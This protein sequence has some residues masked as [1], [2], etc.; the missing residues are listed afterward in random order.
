MG[1]VIDRT[2]HT[3]KFTHGRDDNRTWCG[4]PCASMYLA[5]MEASAAVSTVVHSK[6]R[7]LN[8]NTVV[9]LPE[10]EKLMLINYGGSA[11]AELLTHADGIF[12]EFGDELLNAIGLSTLAMPAVAWT[13]PAT[14]EG[15]NLD[16]QYLQHHLRMGVFPMAPVY[17]ADH[18][19]SD[20]DETVNKLF[21]DYGPLFMNLRGTRWGLDRSAVVRV[22]PPPSAGGPKHNVFEALDPRS[23]LAPWTIVL[24]LAEPFVNSVLV[25]LKLP[26]GNAPAGCEVQLP[27]IGG[28]GVIQRERAVV[29]KQQQMGGEVLIQ[30]QARLWRGCAVLQCSLE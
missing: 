17:G 4:G 22:D 6:N 26:F 16:D 14:Q 9:V 29:L 28:D 10:E 1:V 11:R 15:A 23:S 20:G 18:S 24:A 7:T 25:T 2:D 19:L 12:S 5:W 21:R 8:H 30:L 13:Y 3:T 27:G